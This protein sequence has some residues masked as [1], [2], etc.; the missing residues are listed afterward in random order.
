MYA[1]LSGGWQFVERFSW[2]VIILGLPLA[3]YQLWLLQSD[4][5]RIALELSRT[6]RLVTGF[7]LTHDK[8]DMIREKSFAPTWPPNGAASDPVRIEWVIHNFGSRTA[9][10]ILLNLIIPEA[11]ASV[12]PA[13]GYS[14]QAQAEKLPYLQWKI[15]D[16]NPGDSHTL[17][18]ELPLP[19]HVPV[20][21][22]I[23]TTSMLD[24]A[25]TVETLHLHIQS[26]Q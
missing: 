14:R 20:L 5:N 26:P 25:D 11:F 8:K 12:L 23:V 17:T 15:E 22:I 24:T 16:V 7:G 10:G 6:P 2:V 18:S 13:G 21:E 9:R 1:G 4:Q 19:K 3:V